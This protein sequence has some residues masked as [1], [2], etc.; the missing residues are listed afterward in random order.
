ML[1]E[2]VGEYVQAG[3]EFMLTLTAAGSCRKG[4]Q[5]MAHTPKLVLAGLLSLQMLPNAFGNGDL[6]VVSEHRALHARRYLGNARGLQQEP[7][8]A[9]G[10]AAEPEEAYVPG[11]SLLA[12]YQTFTFGVGLHASDALMLQLGNHVSLI[13]AEDIQNR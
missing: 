2:Y 8:Q 11:I 5:T 6:S 4:K 7:Y 1:R 13:S 12:R 9:D 3:S 10:A